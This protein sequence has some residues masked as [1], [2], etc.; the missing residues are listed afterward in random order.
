M[1]NTVLV[2]L[3]SDFALSL[4]NVKEEFNLKANEID[5]SF[6]VIPLSHPEDTDQIYVVTVSEEAAERM[7]HRPKVEY[8]ATFS[9]SKV[10]P[11][12]P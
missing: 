12:T 6:G 10:S 8:V 5:E 3:K 11:Y 4:Q 9:N 1:S 2:T 7:A